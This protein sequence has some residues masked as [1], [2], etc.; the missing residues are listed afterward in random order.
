MKHT[1]R[2]S[3]A[4]TQKVIDVIQHF[5]DR[6]N[7][8]DLTQFGELFEPDAEYTA[9]TGNTYLGQQNIVKEHIYPFT[10]VNKN[11]AMTMDKLLIRDLSDQLTMVTA[12]WTVTGS[13]SPEG[14]ALP[15]RVGVMQAVINQENWLIRLVCTNDTVDL[16]Q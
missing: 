13:T 6:W 4:T 1:S 12:D 10:T 3:Q 15:A 16:Y 11:A 2:S 9:V 7:A 8:K 5:V 14:E